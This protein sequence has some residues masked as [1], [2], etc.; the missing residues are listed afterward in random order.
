LDPVAAR[1]ADWP[2]AIQAR[3]AGAQRL[4]YLAGDGVDGTYAPSPRCE[5]ALAALGWRLD[6]EWRA[7][8]LVLRRYVHP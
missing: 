7:S 6:Q 5:A 2:A 3:V 1:S 8:P 4:W